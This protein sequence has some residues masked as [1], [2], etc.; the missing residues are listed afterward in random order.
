MTVGD[1]SPKQRHSNDINPF[2]YLG[3]PEIE[4]HD[5]VKPN[6]ERTRFGKLKKVPR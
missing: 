1:L 5:E 3:D 6:K 4:Y 2:E